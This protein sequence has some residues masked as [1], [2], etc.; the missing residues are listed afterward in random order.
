ME[1]LEKNKFNGITML[2]GGRVH[3]GY[4]GIEMSWKEYREWANKNIYNE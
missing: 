2:G 3:N 4:L 1:F